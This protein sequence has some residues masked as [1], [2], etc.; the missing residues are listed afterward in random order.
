[1]LE[2]LAS[3]V[4]IPGAIASRIDGVSSAISVLFSCELKGTSSSIGVSKC[5][6]HQVDSYEDGAAVRRSC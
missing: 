3:L 5:Y 2:K 1:M 4:A 6:L